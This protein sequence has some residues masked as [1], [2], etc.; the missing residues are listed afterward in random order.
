MPWPVLFCSGPRTGAGGENVSPLTTSL[1]KGEWWSGV[2]VGNTLF[3]FSR[4][5]SFLNEPIAG[6]PRHVCKKFHASIR[7]SDSVGPN[8]KPYLTPKVD[9]KL[10]NLHTF[11]AQTPNVHAAFRR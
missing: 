8:I 11:S 5:S 3:F 1:Q 2:S 4:F 9:M 6:A 10:R 7:R